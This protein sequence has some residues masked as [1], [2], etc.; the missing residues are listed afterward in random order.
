MAD[1]VMDPSSNL[2]VAN[3]NVELE[4]L[5]SAGFPPAEAGIEQSV[6][7]TVNNSA[8]AGRFRSHTV[9][10]IQEILI[11]NIT[12]KTTMSADQVEEIFSSLFG[13]E[14]ASTLKA[15]GF[16]QATIT[17]R[18]DGKYDIKIN[19]SNVQNIYTPQIPDVDYIYLAKNVTATFSALEGE[20]YKFNG[21]DGIQL[22]IVHPDYWVNLRNVSISEKDNVSVHAKKFGVGETKEVYQEGASASVAKAIFAVA[23]NAEKAESA[24]S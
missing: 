21:I 14:V 10:E 13:P 7:N 20:G 17:P 4:N 16:E 1:P 2:E 8:T 6:A 22:D 18:E 24:P 15:N 19:L 5:D 12:E 3:R 9:G 11:T 23:E